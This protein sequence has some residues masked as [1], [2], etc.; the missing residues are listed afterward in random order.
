[1]RSLAL[2][3]SLLVLAGGCD[4]ADPP[5]ANLSNRASDL[6]SKK[7]VLSR[8]APHTL[9]GFLLS[10]AEIAPGFAGVYVEGE[11]L[12][13]VVAESRGTGRSELN[14][15]ETIYNAA[16]S[17]LRVLAPVL[18][19]EY[20]IAA[21][22]QLARYAFDDV[23]YWRH[24]LADVT[25]GLRLSDS[26][27]RRGVAVLRFE[28][29][30]YVTD[31]RENAARFGIPADALDAAVG[32]VIER[33]NG[34][35]DAL[36]SPHLSPDYVEGGN[37]IRIETSGPF[38]RNKLCT[39]GTM[40]YRGQTSG[41]PAGFITNSHCTS[42]NGFVGG[43]QG[44]SYYR[45]G[46]AFGGNNFLGIET[47]DPN[48]QPAPVN[49][50]RRRGES[51]VPDYT[52]PYRYSD[53]AFIDFDAAMTASPLFGQII[54][55]DT[56]GTTGPGSSG[57][58]GAFEIVEDADSY[59]QFIGTIVHKMG[60]TTN[61][62]VG[63]IADDPDRNPGESCF[64]Y[65][66][67][68]FLSTGGLDPNYGDM[69]VCQNRVNAYADQGDSGAPVFSVLDELEKR[70]GQPEAR[71]QGLLWGEDGVSYVFSP[72]RGITHDLRASGGYGALVTH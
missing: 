58:V 53:A 16:V 9:D 66:F 37:G 48:F 17:A 15:D 12:H 20:Q 38:S 31:A 28:S 56:A 47:F 54:R 51:V 33:A 52:R 21:S 2:S 14:S 36:A 59:H 55:T 63:A 50:A 39:Y 7:E 6:P 45:R 43:V 65:V 3:L 42:G 35:S 40:V 27:E 8:V 62:T 22:P 32:G 71:F 13:I 57:R 69:L 18:F 10:V 25:E 1:M 29:D 46:N 24:V 34:G 60:S 61:R 19:E 23:T 41:A 64:D 49:N 67:P 68:Q 5:S 70:G 26:D 30:E 44:H 4:S 11:V 72:Y